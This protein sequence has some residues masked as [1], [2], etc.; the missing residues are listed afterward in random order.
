MK[1]VNQTISSQLEGWAEML[2]QGDLYS[3]EQ[4]LFSC[5]N[6]IYDF[7]SEELLPSVSCQVIDK[8]VEQGRASGGRKIEVRPFTFRI[9]TGREVKVQS[10]YVR[11]PG[12][13]WSGSRHLLAGHWNVIGGASPAL[14][15]RVGFCAALG[16]SYD[17]AH[18]ALGKFGA[19]LCLS[20]V[21]DLTNRLADHCFDYGEENLMLEPSETLADKR[22]AIAVDG[23]R[24]RTRTYEGEVNQAGQLMY[25]T[26]WCEP[27]LFVIEVL[28]NEGRP[29]RHELPIY[30]CRFKKGHVLN[31]LGRYLRTLEIDKAEQVQILG[32]GAGWIWN[33]IKPMLL[34]LNVDSNRIVE[35]LDY[36]HA[37]QYVH[38]LVDQMPKRIGQNRRK[39][40]LSQFKDWLW[41]GAAGQIV[42]EC[43]TVYK[44]PGDLVE[45]WINYLDKHQDKTQYAVYE[46]N[47]LMCGSGIIESGIRR[48]INLRFKNA[49]TF[50]E[51]GTVEKLYFLRA[52]LLSKRWD[53][54]MINLSNST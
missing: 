30:G 12:K 48:I 18:Q 52:A 37:S 13:A 21:R 28:N 53:T 43:K 5:M 16:P 14:Y 38:S 6:G 35:S 40:Y 31:L 45:R 4:G 47:K 10:P 8:L 50:W 46:E 49:S 7:I 9:A 20:S 1:F 32:D 26:E 27:K 54:V 2:L 11:K 19:T 29:S 25:Q 34:G 17:V 33:N 36:Y 22:V 24:T 51:K 15:D 44:R 3:Y 39:A 23:G 42:E 41:K